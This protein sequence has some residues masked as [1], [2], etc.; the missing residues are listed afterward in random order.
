MI[1]HPQLRALYGLNGDVSISIVRDDACSHEKPQMPRP[2]R[3][4]LRRCATEP[5]FGS[6]RF[7]RVNR[8]GR[9][10][11]LDDSTIIICRWESSPSAGSRSRTSKDMPPVLKRTAGGPPITITKSASIAA[12]ASMDRPPTYTR[13]SYSTDSIENKSCPPVIIRDALNHIKE[14]VSCS[15]KTVAF[16]QQPEEL[17]EEAL[18]F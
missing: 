5:D 14:E 8:L 7:F 16:P 2:P 13:P 17:S 1:L 12:F 15:D 11:S 6:K 3:A 9:R 18:S 4:G 10:S